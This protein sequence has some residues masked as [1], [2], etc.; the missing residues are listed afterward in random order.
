MKTL[1]IVIIVLMLSAPM[2]AEEGILTFETDNSSMAILT[3]A[4]PTSITFHLKDGKEAM[5]DFSGDSLRFE[6]NVDES[7]RL[8]FNH[9]FQQYVLPCRKDDQK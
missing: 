6:G 4:P 9:L 5:I 8:F 1:A 7:A 2:W 3:I